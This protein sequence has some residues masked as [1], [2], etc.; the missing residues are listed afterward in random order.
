MLTPRPPRPLLRILVHAAAGVLALAAAAEEAREQA[1]TR[2]AMQ[3]IPVLPSRTDPEIKAFDFPHYIYADRDILIR[4]DEKKPAPRGEL[5]VWM[6]G[7]GG[8]GRGAVE[9]CRLAAA[10]GY[11]VVNLVYPS[12]IPATVCKRRPDPGSFEE[13]RLCII[14]GGECR[15]ITVSR[16]DSMENRLVKLLAHLGKS[17]AREGW[18]DYLQED[19]GLAWEKLALAGQ[20]QG[21]GHAF[22]MGMRHR[23]ARVIATGAPKD[24]SLTAGRARPLAAGRVRD[25]EGPLFRLQS[26]A[27]PPGLHAGPAMAHPAGVRPGGLRPPR[28]RGRAAAALRPQPHPEHQPPRRQARV[29]PR[30]CH[31]HRQRQRGV[32]PP[33]VETHAHRPGRVS[34]TGHPP[35][36]GMTPQSLDAGRR[37]RLARSIMRKDSSSTVPLRVNLSCPR[38][39]LAASFLPMPAKG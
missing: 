7:T 20:S 19:G 10:S 27:G 6:T 11:H 39:T 37:F 13:F 32:L 17:R 23:V 34:A 28:L 8:R 31:R 1:L 36:R 29:Q 38:E 14:Q 12:D 5:L 4:R 30:P 15:A 18:G 24:W 35:S 26:R 33:G 22:L 2:E 9:F 21:G 25:P 16:A 3:G